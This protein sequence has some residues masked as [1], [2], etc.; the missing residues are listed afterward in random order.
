MYS[1]DLIN[2]EIEAKCTVEDQDYTLKINFSKAIDKD[3]TE[4]LTFNAIF[5][6]KMMRF[7]TFEQ[8]GRHCFYRNLITIFQVFKLRN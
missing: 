2:D 3:D 4:T 6:K 1:H 8:V 7:M 5:S